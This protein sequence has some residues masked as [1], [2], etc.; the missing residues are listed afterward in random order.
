[1]NCSTGEVA[2]Q[3][4]RRAR[5][6]TGSDAV[7]GYHVASFINPVLSPNVINLISWALFKCEWKYATARV[8]MKPF[9]LSYP[10]VNLF[11]P[12]MDLKKSYLHSF[13]SLPFVFS[14]GPARAISSLSVARMW[15]V[16]CRVSLW[17]RNKLLDSTRADS[18]VS[19]SFISSSIISW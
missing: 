7:V 9:F 15:E 16:V 5:S 8:S 18:L 13:T 3:V 11:L 12:H 6:E 2:D 1:M 4:C 17:R 10:H 19:Q 14:L